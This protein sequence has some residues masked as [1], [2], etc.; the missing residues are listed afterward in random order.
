MIPRYAIAA[1]AVGLPAIGL[2]ALAYRAASSLSSSKPLMIAGLDPLYVALI[3]GVISTFLLA[4][5]LGLYA[6]AKGQSA[7]L[8]LL[9]VFS[10][11]GLLVVAFLPDQT[12][13]KAGS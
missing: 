5:A 12:K 11:F 6:R 2:Q 7:F 1:L 4:V 8:G 9:A 10:C 13:T 3:G